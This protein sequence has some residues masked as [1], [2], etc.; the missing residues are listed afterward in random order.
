[1]KAFSIIVAIAQNKAIGKDNLLLWHLSEDLKRFKKL[2]LGH[3]VIMGYKTYL[4]LPIHP[5]PN[6]KNIV[7]VDD[8]SIALDGCTMAHSIEEAI[9]FAD[10]DKENFIVGGGSI[11][12]QFLPICQK[13]YITKVLKDF[14]A[15]TFFPSFKETEYILEKESEIFVDEKTQLPYQYL[16]YTK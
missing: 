16:V 4:S 3:T 2:T 12:A 7:I 5:F 8:L 13:L 6:R 15:D 11:Y 14:E 10:E 1:M 9:Q